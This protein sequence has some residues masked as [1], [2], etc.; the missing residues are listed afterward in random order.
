MNFLSF[1]DLVA[2][3]L[4]LVCLTSSVMWGTLSTS[5][6][7]LQPRHRVAAQ[8]MHRIFSVAGLEFLGLHIWVKV[9]E[10][11]VGVIG[12]A[13]PFSGGRTNLLVSLG[14]LAAYGFVVTVISGV[15]RRWFAA[16]S[17]RPAWWRVLHG[18]SYCAWGA[19]LVHGLYAGRAAASWVMGMYQASLT[20]V[21]IVVIIRWWAAVR[22]R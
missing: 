21:A 2:G 3:V 12:A 6:W 15:L 4:A 10:G 1:A 14:I 8:G 11:S 22:R 17:R 16:R 13:I 9:Y 20:A 18:T 19:A 7:V 5:E